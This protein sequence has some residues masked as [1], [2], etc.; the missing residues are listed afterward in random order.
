MCKLLAGTLTPSLG[1]LHF[2]YSWHICRL[3]PRI[4]VPHGLCKVA[5]GSHIRACARTASLASRVLQVGGCTDLPVSEGERGRAARRVKPEGPV[6]VTDKQIKFEALV[7]VTDEYFYTGIS[8]TDGRGSCDP[9]LLNR[10]L[11]KE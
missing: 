6:E 3:P 5:L 4:R 7:E 10:M 2:V 1:N 8:L 9:D 11:R